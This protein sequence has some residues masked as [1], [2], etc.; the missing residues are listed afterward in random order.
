MNFYD[1]RKFSFCKRITNLRNSLPEDIVTS[2]S[3]NSLKN[4][5]DKNWHFHEVRF[6]WQAEITGSGSR[7]KVI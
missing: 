5:F 2:T 6:N 7:S 3:L 4:K 1:L